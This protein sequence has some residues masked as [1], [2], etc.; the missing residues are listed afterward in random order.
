M[1]YYNISKGRGYPIIKH[2]LRI[3]EAC[4]EFEV[5]LLPSQF[6]RATDS[7]GTRNRSVNDHLIELRSGVVCGPI[8]VAHLASPCGPIFFVRA[9]WELL[10]TCRAP[11]CF[12]TYN[13]FI[14]IS[15]HRKQQ[16][17]NYM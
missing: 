5:K 7:I 2:Y 10:Q 4:P 11:D 14:F 1:A 15:V 13:T 8:A 17:A 6:F 3:I 16:L 9:E 12:A